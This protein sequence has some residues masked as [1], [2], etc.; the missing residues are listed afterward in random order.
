MLLTRALLIVAT[1]FAVSASLAFGLWNSPFAGK[2]Q[3]PDTV[4]FAVA[5]SA[6]YLLLLFATT[7][8]LSERLKIITVVASVVATLLG[9]FAYYGAFRPNDGEFWLMFIIAPIIQ[10]FFAIPISVAAAWKPQNKTQNQSSA[11]Q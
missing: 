3:L 7:R 6:P 10:A 2:Q 4:F 11:R 9:L 5:A 1:L 8:N